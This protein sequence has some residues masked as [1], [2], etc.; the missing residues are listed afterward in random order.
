VPGGLFLAGND[1]PY[2]GRVFYVRL[3]YAW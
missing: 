2:A 3:S 1:G